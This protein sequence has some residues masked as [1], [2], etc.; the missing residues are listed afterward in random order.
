MMQVREP[1]RWSPFTKPEVDQAT[2]QGL[3]QQVCS[4]EHDAFYELVRPYERV[5]Y[6]ATHA[7]LRND[8]DAEDAAQEA[9]LKAFL[10]LK[11]F[12]S[13]SKFSTWLIQIAINEARMHLRRAKRNLHDSLDEGVT[14]PD[15]NYIPRDFADWR[16]IPSQE[17]EREELRGALERALNSLHPRYREVFILRDVERLSIAETAELL[18]ISAGNVKIRLLRA[19]L[20]MR[21]ALAPGFDGSW[22]S[23]RS[24]KKV[25]PW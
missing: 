6:L 10:H 2:E 24:Y 25:R 13:E 15:G 1:Q 4:G 20:Q 21:D 7:L 12:R 8:E 23:E 5:V 3:I 19:R 16:E 11:G 18:G 22:R 14:D 17:L 9:I